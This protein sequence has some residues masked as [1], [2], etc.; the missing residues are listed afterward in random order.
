[1]TFKMP[2]DRIDGDAT[3]TKTNRSKVVELKNVIITFISF[4][5]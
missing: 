2:N 4:D 3:K 5:I 1:M